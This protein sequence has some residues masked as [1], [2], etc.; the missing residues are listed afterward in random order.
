MK[1]NTQRG[2]LHSMRERLGLVTLRVDIPATD[3][4]RIQAE[5]DA[6]MKRARERSTDKVGWAVYDSLK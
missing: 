2:K 6:A 4:A 3:A 5:I 1:T